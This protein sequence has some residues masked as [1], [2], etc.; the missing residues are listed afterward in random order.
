MVVIN[1]CRLQ[2]SCSQMVWAFF[3][4][5]DTL[6]FYYVLEKTRAIIWANKS[7]MVKKYQISI[8]VTVDPPI[9]LQASSVVYCGMLQSLYLACLLTYYPFSVL[10]KM[11]GISWAKN[12]TAHNKK[13]FSIWYNYL[14]NCW[15]IDQSPIF[16]SFI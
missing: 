13:V 7:M 1:K 14:F 16:Y 15:P 4:W 12:R 10:V 11:Y 6:I 3:A 8:C 5:S 2:K 9:N